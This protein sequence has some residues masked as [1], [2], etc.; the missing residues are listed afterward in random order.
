MRTAR[1]FRAATPVAWVRWRVMQPL[2]HYVL[3]PLKRR[4]ITPTLTWGGD[5]LERI[6]ERWRP[7]IRTRDRLA[8]HHQQQ[9]EQPMN[10]Q[11]EARRA[12]LLSPIGLEPV[13]N[14][15]G[16]ELAPL[17]EKPTG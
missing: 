4:L 11:P 1:I 2:I 7:P 5:Q 14:D 3:G 16:P 10:G 9:Q 8:R 13:T 12:P 17:E 15:P 6:P